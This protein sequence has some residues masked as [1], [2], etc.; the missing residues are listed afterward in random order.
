MTKKDFVVIAK[1]LK[2]YRGVL[3]N[4]NHYD[5]VSDFV[6]ELEKINPQFNTLT[7]L[8]ASNRSWFR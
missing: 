6:T 8:Q 1:I 3:P 2:K 4:E 5:L 7:F